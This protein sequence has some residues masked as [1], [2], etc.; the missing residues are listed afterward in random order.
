MAFPS[1]RK[2]MARYQVTRTTVRSA[3]GALKQEGMVVSEH[4]AG[5]FVRD[6]KADRRRVDARQVGVVRPDAPGEAE[7]R[8]AAGERAFRL[9]AILESSERRMKV[10]PWIGEL[11][12]VEIGTEVLVQE[13]TGLDAG[14]APSLCWAWLHPKVEEQLGL[15]EADLAGRWLPTCWQARGCRAGR[16][17]TWWRPRCRHPTSSRPWR[18]RTGCRCSSCTG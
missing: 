15:A 12:Q 14:G 16:V 1:E 7:P 3:I 9:Q 5:S 2:L 18:C 13:T 10:T 17:R 4:G 8:R 6:P 11:L